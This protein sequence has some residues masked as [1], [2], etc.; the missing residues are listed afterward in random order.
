MSH[1]HKAATPR[2]AGNLPILIPTEPLHTPTLFRARRSLTP[3]RSNTRPGWR[4]IACACCVSASCPKAGRLLTYRLPGLVALCDERGGDRFG[5]QS[6][7]GRGEGCRTTMASPGQQYHPE[8]LIFAVD[9]DAESG[10]EG[11][12]PMHGCGVLL[13]SRSRLAPCAG[14]LSPHD[15]RWQS[16]MC[17]PPC[18]RASVLDKPSLQGHDTMGADAAVHRHDYAGQ[19]VFYG[20][21]WDVRG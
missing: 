16:T 3:V 7:Q 5:G 14:P 2:L 9:L 8:T 20:L 12:G 21:G 11:E 19:G 13:G 1:K 17:L 18:V 4:S 6:F 10:L 15:G